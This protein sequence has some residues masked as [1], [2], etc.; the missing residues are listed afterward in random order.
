MDFITTFKHC[1]T[2]KQHCRNV[3]ISLI[4]VLIIIS[5]LTFGQHK[6]MNIGFRDHGLCFG[7]SKKNDGIRLNLWDRMVDAT[8]GINISGF[9][10]AI[11]SNGIGIGLLGCND[12]IRNGISIGGIGVGGNH[13]NGLAIGGLAVAG[14]KINGFGISCCWMSADTMNGI[15]ISGLGSSKWSTDSIKIIN[16]ISIGWATGVEC[17]KLNGLAIGLCN[18]I[19]YQNGVTIAI[20]NSTK[21]LHGFQF[22]IWNIAENNKIFKKMPIMNFN[23]RRKRRK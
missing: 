22:G 10:S 5:S 16:G 17:V 12:S 1:D 3:R 2:M 4:F 23:L 18:H 14:Y 8:N 20:K 9:S 13:I 15:F 11:K 6:Y 21:H 19:S 7:N